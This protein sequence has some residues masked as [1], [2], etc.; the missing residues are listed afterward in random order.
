MI[1]F[2]TETTGVAIEICVTHL[3]G[4]S[5]FYGTGKSLICLGVSVS[6]PLFIEHKTKT[7]TATHA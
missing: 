3:G 5:M 2:K 6:R 1:F 7:I 4:R